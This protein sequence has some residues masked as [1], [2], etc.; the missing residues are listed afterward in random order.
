MS[1][2]CNSQDKAPE[3]TACPTKC[4]PSCNSYLQATCTCKTRAFLACS[5]T[6]ALWTAWLHKG[7]LEKNTWGRQPALHSLH[8]Q[9]CHTSLQARL[10]NGWF[11]PTSMPQD[12]WSWANPIRL[13]RTAQREDKAVWAVFPLPSGI[14]HS[15][16]LFLKRLL[17]YRRQRPPWD[18][19]AGSV[20]P[21]PN[22]KNAYLPLASQH[23]A[24]MKKGLPLVAGSPRLTM[25][26]HKPVFWYRSPLVEHTLLVRDSLMLG[27]LHKTHWGLP[28]THLLMEKATEG[29]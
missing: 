3:L 7:A 22:A 15:S 14:D 18:T 9:S 5:T 21:R 20:A 10:L 25:I 17:R 12:G 1:Q 6:G 16:L 28:G 11:R 4:V 19:C 26:S 29:T 23:S 24:P 27:P 13:C 2:A 8:R